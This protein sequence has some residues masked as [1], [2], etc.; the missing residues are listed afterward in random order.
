[1]RFSPLDSSEDFMRRG[2]L[3]FS[4]S[5]IVSELWRHH[6]VIISDADCTPGREPRS[7]A[8]S[9]LNI[10]TVYTWSVAEMF[11]WAA[12]LSDCRL[13]K[14][15]GDSELL[16]EKKTIKRATRWPGFMWKMSDKRCATCLR[17]LLWYRVSSLMMLRCSRQLVAGV[18]LCSIHLC[19]VCL[20]S[21]MICLMLIEPQ[22]AKLCV[23]STN[24][25][26]G[27]H[28]HDGFA[29]SW[30]VCIFT[31]STVV[32]VNVAGSHCVLTAQQSLAFTHTEL[33]WFLLYLHVCQ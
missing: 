1:M 9:C 29:Y 10:H 12:W 28:I 24:S 5:L 3:R 27:L 22:S 31:N 26:T 4:L 18:W 20:F 8:A 7:V 6:D 19:V 11:G 14:L 2:G 25:L 32:V 23:P 15:F 16:Y 33:C 17:V 21:E 30:Q 13:W